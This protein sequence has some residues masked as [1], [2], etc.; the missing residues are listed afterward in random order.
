MAGHR[1]LRGDGTPPILQSSQVRH[2]SVADARRA[3]HNWVADG[4]F[5]TQDCNHLL[6]MNH[7]AVVSKLTTRS[8]QK[9][10]CWTSFG[11]LFSKFSKLVTAS[12]C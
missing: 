9:H 1:G 3:G 6:T 7:Q 8:I 2:I 11:T 4:L 10:C 5:H 12:N